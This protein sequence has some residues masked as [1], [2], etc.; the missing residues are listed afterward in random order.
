MS[1]RR[2]ATLLAPALAVTLALSA[3]SDGAPA[4]DSSSSA[5]TGTAADAVLVEDAWVKAADSGMSAAFGVV[6][7]TGDHDVTVQGAT[8]PTATGVELHETV[9][10]GTGAMVMQEKDGGFTV[11]AGGELVLEPGGNHLMLMGL[12][13]PVEAGDE[14]DLT[15]TF[16]DGSTLDVT[17]PAKDYS[18]ANENYGGDQ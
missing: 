17:A 12:T 4:A 5:A 13:A 11:P 15:L 8:S 14:V 10:D 9:D 16:D 3:C 6:R 1:A 2:T 7:N 18:G